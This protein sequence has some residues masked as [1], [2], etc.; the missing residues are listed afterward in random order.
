MEKALSRPVNPA[1]TLPGVGKNKMNGKIKKSLKTKRPCNSK[2][3]SGHLPIPSESEYGDC[4]SANDH[5]LRISG[6]TAVNN[7][8]RNNF[9]RVLERADKFE[10]RASISGAG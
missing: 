10:K 6:V 4:K 3:G 5:Q 7:E 2:S 9:Y 8:T 1:L